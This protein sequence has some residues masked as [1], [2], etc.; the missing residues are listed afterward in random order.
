MHPAVLNTLVAGFLLFQASTPPP[1][2]ASR[3]VRASATRSVYETTAPKPKEEEKSQNSAA[4]LPHVKRI[5]V[6]NFGEDAISRELQAMVVDA[7]VKSKRFVVTENK[8][9]ADAIM[10]GSALEKTSQEFHAIGEG[11]GAAVAAGAESGSFSGTAGSISGSHRGAFGARAA[12]ADDAQAST[13]TINDARA[14]V[15]LVDPDGD[16]IW[17]TTQESKF[18]KYK[19]SSAD[20]ADRIVKQLLRDV[21]R[22]ETNTERTTSP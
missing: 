16:V 9:K 7:L 4:K 12:T 20:V 14:A 11:A 3:P 15:R 2:T 8:D 1:T 10:K 19:S 21:E 5:Y 17:T 13:E 22:L 6:D 18:A